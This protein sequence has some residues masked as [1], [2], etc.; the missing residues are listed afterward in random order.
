MLR[1]ALVRFVHV[2]AA[3]V[4]L[5]AVLGAQT[6]SQPVRWNAQYT[7]V[8][9]D[10]FENPND[11][12]FQ[13][14]SPANPPGS[15]NSA[16]ITHDPSL[17]IAG[18]AAVRM[19][20]FGKLVTVPSSLP[21]TGGNT[22]VVEFQYRIVNPGSVGDILHFNLQPAGTTD[23]SLDVDF[24]YMGSKT[25]NPAGGTFSTGAFLA[26]ASAPYVLTIT[27]QFQTDVVID[28][29]AVYRQDPT[30]SSTAPTAWNR[31]ESLPYPR[32]AKYSQTNPIVNSSLR[33]DQFE[34]LLSLYD[35]AFGLNNEA[36][37]NIP[38]FGWRMR[39]LNPN[40]VL[41]PYRIAVEQG[42]DQ[43]GMLVTPQGNTSNSN[44]HLEYQ[45][46]KSI[47]DSWYLRT[48]AG[49]YVIEQDYPSGRIMDLSTY[50]PV[51][52]GQTYVTALSDWLK[53][54]ILPSGMWDGIFLDNLYASINQH[55]VNYQDPALFDLDLNRN[56]IRDD[57]PAQISE[58]SRVGALSLLQQFRQDNGDLELLL[59]NVGSQSLMPYVNGLLFECYNYHWNTNFGVAGSGKSPSSWRAALDRWRLV[60]G[61][62]RH[63]RIPVFEA[64]GPQYAFSG[65]DQLYT[66]PTL[67]DI[68][69]ERFGIATTLLGDGFYGF[70]L[71]GFLSDPYWYDEYSV[72]TTG[73]AVQGAP[74]KGYL[75]RALTDGTQLTDGGVQVFGEN[76]EGGSLPPSFSINTAGGIGSIYVSPSP[77]E[78]IS[79]TGSLIISNPDHTKR[80]YVSAATNAGVLPLPASSYALVFD[81]RILE[82]VDTNF[83]V[84]LWAPT[85][86]TVDSWMCPEMIAGDSGTAVFPFQIG[87]ADA[88]SIIFALS[89]GG[90][91]VAIDNVR[92]FQGGS[93]PWRRDFENGF[94]LVNPYLTPYTF[95]SDQIAGALHRTNV[96]RIKGTQAPD[97]NNGQ[98]VGALTLQPFDGIVL[99]ADHIDAATAARPQP[100][101]WWDPKLNG[102]GFFIEYGGK[103]SSGMFVG[104]FLYDASGDATW[105][106]STGQMTGP[107]YTGT[108][109]KVSGGQT[110]LGPYQTP[111]TAQAGNLNITF[112][113]STHGVMTRPDGTQINLQRF[114]FTG[115]TPTPPEPGMPQ[116]G[117]WWAGSALS[118]TGYGIEIQGLSVFIVAYV[119]DDAGDPV[120]YLATGNLTTPTSYSGTWDGYAGGPQLTSPEGPYSAHKVSSATPMTLTFSDATHGTLTMGSVTVPITR[121]Q[122]F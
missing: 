26:P 99:L 27:S 61:T 18:T 9:F 94:V 22:Y 90:G 70:D 116:N 57:S 107:T 11:P 93:G 120:W 96:R 104:G 73:T 74:Q 89:G 25:S 55:I 42:T 16:L 110:L 56:G 39:A 53:N 44:V 12:A 60:T 32:L 98:A 88:W 1:V 48:S 24:Q 65:Q 103:S 52:N 97:I 28:N 47:P 100:G 119:Y 33:Q 86:G 8:F 50:A 106:V 95:T 105:L 31:L 36:T 37:T 43:N 117:W 19:G 23:P 118:G 34:S 62:A 87:S 66:T 20:W 112:S 17:V 46:F 14:L 85:P 81:W 92:L 10:D 113:D 45:L 2:V 63:P 76:F 82:T 13:L 41:L 78:I 111:S 71:H 38:A 21:L 49:Q 79:G 4:V 30:P 109:L 68:V 35:M 5:A 40:E 15:I 114:S 75:G 64:C 84:D 67:D 58:M 91:K 59:G 102:T 122:E 101:W 77:G 83:R 3:V 7:R 80:N 69:S 115:P 72:D 108:W 6:G 54:R 121:F 29:F 51:V